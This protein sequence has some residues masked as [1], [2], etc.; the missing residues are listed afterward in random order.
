MCIILALSIVGPLIAVMSYTDDLG[1]IG[2][3]VGEVAGILTQKELD[4]PE[5]QRKSLMIIL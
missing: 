3:V 4:R 2:T 1:K 5:N